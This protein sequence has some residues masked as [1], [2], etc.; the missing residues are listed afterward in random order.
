MAI[1]LSA[2]AM[3][4]PPG[5]ALGTGTGGAEAFADADRPSF[6]CESSPGYYWCEPWNYSKDENASREYPLVVFLHGSGGAGDISYLW[7]LGYGD[8]DPRARAFQAAH[9]CFVLVPQT[10]GSWDDKA[11]IALIEDFRKGRR[12]DPSRLYLIGYSMGG[13]E[14]FS[15]ANACYDS[16]KTLFAGIVRIAGQSQ[17]SV[18]DAIAAK[19]AIWLHIGLID[20]RARIKTTREAYAFLKKR[21]PNA[22]EYSNPAGV[23]SASGTTL[24]LRADGVELDKKTEYDG[25][26]HGIASLPFEDPAVIEWLFARRAR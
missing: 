11:L 2:A 20:D 16:D 17:S 7:Y 10:S 14:S 21:N 8:A 19:S 9:P 12:I 1:A 15:L 26:G 5:F 4:A 22:V 13:S 23:P 3:V 18:R 24:T 6:S 25:V